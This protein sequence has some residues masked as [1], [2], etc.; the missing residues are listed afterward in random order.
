MYSAKNILITLAVII[1]TVLTFIIRE[2]P[3]PDTSE[4]FD[5]AL[6][7]FHVVNSATIIMLCL[8]YVSGVLN[9]IVK[10]CLFLMCGVNII[11]ICKIIIGIANEPKYSDNALMFG[12][13]V[14]SLS[15]AFGKHIKTTTRAGKS[16]ANNLYMKWHQRKTDKTYGTKD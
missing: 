6:L 9:R 11:I 12:V 10:F 1:V 13:F 5:R 8:S 14:F 4:A 16:A 2:L 15:L 3:V 7:I